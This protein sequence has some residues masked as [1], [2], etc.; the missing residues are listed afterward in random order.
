LAVRIKLCV[1]NRETGASIETSALV[2]TGFETDSPQLL[3]P[4][5]AA[6]ELGLWPPPGGALKA[7]YDTAG[8]PTS[9][10]VCPRALAVKVVVEDRETPWVVADAIIS[11]I[12]HE[13]LVSDKLMGALGIAIEDGAEGLWRFRSEGLDK[14]RRSEPPQLW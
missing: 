14:L 9:I 13:L 7:I 6:R 10:W 5:G 3:L 2:N 8:G 11:T 12:E 1:K 4:V